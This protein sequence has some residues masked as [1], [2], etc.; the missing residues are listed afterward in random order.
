MT[1]RLLEEMSLE[2]QFWLHVRKPPIQGN[3]LVD[4]SIRAAEKLLQDNRGTS[5]ELTPFFTGLNRIMFYTLCRVAERAGIARKEPS[6]LLTNE[7]FWADF[8]SRAAYI[9]L[10]PGPPQ[11]K[12]AKIQKRMFKI[13]KE[14]VKDRYARNDPDN[15]R[16][17]D[18]AALFI[19]NFWN[20]TGVLQIV[21]NG[22]LSLNQ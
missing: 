10:K 21:E 18:L 15:A 2:A 11:T 22:I 1:D 4:M 12:K 5:R 8:C 6:R 14:L 19:F 13:C 16:H 7:D 17:A 9:E 20:A 3:F